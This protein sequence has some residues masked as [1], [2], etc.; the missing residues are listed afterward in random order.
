MA[1][2]DTN[3][4]VLDAEAPSQFKVLTVVSM[5][6]LSL[7]IAWA[8]VDPRLIDGVPV[9]MKPLKFSLS[10]VALF[11]TLALIEPLLSDRARRGVTLKLT[12]WAMAAAYLLE[13][14]YMFYMAARAEASHFNLSTPWHQT[15]YTLMGAGAVTLIAGVAVFGWV[16]RQDERAAM[17]PALREGIWLGFLATFLLTFVVAGYLSS[18]GGHFVGLH[19]EGAP[20]LPLFG[21]SGVTGD[22]RPAHFASIHAMQALPLLGLW[23]DR[24]GGAGSV[25]TVR[26]A[27]LGYGG[28][29]LALFGQALLG[30][31]LILLG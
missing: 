2:L 18:S 27:A 11:G 19:P 25:R 13:M 14:A 16:V 17:G 8:F 12:G 24:R 28:L 15:M 10:F 22:L 3:P 5:L 4:P 1:L 29:T 23:L 7:S 26:I 6:L 30:L 9:W 20:T 21:W 31:P